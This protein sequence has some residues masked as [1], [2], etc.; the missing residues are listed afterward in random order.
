MTYIFHKKIQHYNY[1]FHYRGER[2]GRGRAKL[3]SLA[4]YNEDESNDLS[5]LGIGTSSASGKSSQSEDYDN[6]SVLV[7]LMKGC[8]Y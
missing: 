8:F 5:D 2:G 6:N 3:A 4:V 7:G 1:N